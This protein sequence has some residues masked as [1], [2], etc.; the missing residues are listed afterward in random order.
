MPEAT[1]PISLSLARR[2]IKQL[3]ARAHTVSGTLTGVARHLILTGL[4]GGDGKAVAER[5]VH[6]E[7]R[8]AALEGLAR[9]LSVSTQGIAGVMAGVPSASVRVCTLSSAA[10]ERLAG[11]TGSRIRAASGPASSMKVSGAQASIMC[12][13][14]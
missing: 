8:L 2:D 14:T 5:L 6:M 1:L 9:E 7:R 11:A 3:K 4:A 10:C 12:H 13:C